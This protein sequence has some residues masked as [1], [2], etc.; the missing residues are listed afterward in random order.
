M[1]SKRSPLQRINRIMNH[2]RLMGVNKEN[3]KIV[4]RNVLKKRVRTIP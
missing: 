1:K 2:Y 4:Y 3:L